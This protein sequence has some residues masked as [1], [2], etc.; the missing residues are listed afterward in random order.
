M[1][2]PEIEP[3]S[4]V[5]PADAEGSEWHDTAGSVIGPAFQPRARLSL[6]QMEVR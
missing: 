4:T 3:T 2:I 1:G 6:T 5:G